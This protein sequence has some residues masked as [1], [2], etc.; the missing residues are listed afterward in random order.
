MTSRAHAR[1]AAQMFGVWAIKPDF[2]RSAVA[3]VTAGTWPMRGDAPSASDAPYELRNGVAVLELAGPITKYTSSFAGT[4]STLDLRKSLRAAVAD[5]EVKSILL[6]MDSPGGCVDGT[7]DAAREIYDAARK[8]AVEVYTDGM[9]DSAAYWIASQATRITAGETAEVGSIGTLAVVEDCSG[10]YDAAGVKVHVVSTGPIK[11][12][13]VDG[14]PIR[15][16]HLDY[17]QTRVNDLNEFFLTAVSRGRGI[18]MREVRKLATGEDWLARKAKS[19]GLIDAVDTLDNVLKRMQAGD[20]KPAK[21]VTPE[22]YNGEREEEADLP[23]AERVRELCSDVRGILEERCEERMALPVNET[24]S[25][26]GESNGPER[27]MAGGEVEVRAAED[28]GRAYITGYAAVY[29]APTTIYDSNGEF[30]EIVC[31]GAFDEFLAGGQDVLCRVQH[32]GGLLTIGRLSNGSL[33]LTSDGKG[34]RYRCYTPN[35]TAGRDVLEMARTGLMRGSSF[36]FIVNPDGQQ[37]ETRS[38]VPVRRLTSLT[39]IDVAPVDDP[40]Y[41][42]TTL[43]ASRNTQPCTDPDVV[44]R[45]LD[46]ELRASLQRRLTQY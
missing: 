42:A 21:P 8:K 14:A 26:R 3:S 44:A 30:Q 10:A 1:C 24:R 22:D 37:W 28:N 32:Q 43:A 38:A 33:E 5:N 19:L 36:A 45:E 27:R 4:M 15:P 23:A 13:F 39:L 7:A 46:A 35:T 11:G 16:E 34:L 25:T 29:D 31:R 40:A 17:L 2:L 18:G 12:A 9:L 20:G 6:I 41:E